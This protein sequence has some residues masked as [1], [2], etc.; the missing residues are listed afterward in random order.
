MR[1]E[2]HFYLSQEKNGLLRTINVLAFFR[3]IW[4]GCRRRLVDAEETDSG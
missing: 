1:Q 4:V 2:V 3:L